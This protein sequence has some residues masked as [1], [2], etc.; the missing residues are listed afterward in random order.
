MR[1]KGGVALKFVSPGTP[2]VPDRIVIMP[3]SRVAFVELKTDT[4]RVSAAQARVHANLIRL[5]ADVHTLY[6]RQDVEA[7]LDGL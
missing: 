1:K 6:G 7:F 5:G 4:G 2:G 3:G